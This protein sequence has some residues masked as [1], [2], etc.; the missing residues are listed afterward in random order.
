MVGFR[1]K[2]RQKRVQ[3]GPRYEAQQASLCQASIVGPPELGPTYLG[4]YLVCESFL[5]IT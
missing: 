3:I 5:E 1:D 2:E 4:V